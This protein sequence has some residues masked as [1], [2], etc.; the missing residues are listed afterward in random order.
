MTDSGLMKPAKKTKFSIN[1]LESLQEKC[2]FAPKSHP[3]KCALSVKSRP[4]KCM[5]TEKSR[6]EKCKTKDYV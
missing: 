2:I 3:E 4:E 5:A 1:H 6:P